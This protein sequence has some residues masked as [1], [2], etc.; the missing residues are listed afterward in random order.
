MRRVLHRRADRALAWH[1]GDRDAAAALVEQVLAELLAAR[2]LDDAR[3]ARAWVDD[4]DRRGIPRRS[5][6]QRLL[7]KGVDAAL[8]DDALNARDQQVVE[9]ELARACA[10]ARRRRLGAARPEHRRPDDPAL[11][12]ARRD[13]DVAALCRAGFSVGVALQVIDCPD[14]DALAARAGEET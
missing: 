13:K 10:Y 5:M 6:R 12:R 3:F 8:I 14:L 1:G 11:R 7:S 2:L 9:P 4:L